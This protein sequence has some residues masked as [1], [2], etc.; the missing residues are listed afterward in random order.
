MSENTTPTRDELAA[1]LIAHGEFSRLGEMRNYENALACADAI[2]AL[3]AEALTAA[4]RE[5]DDWMRLAEQSPSSWL[6]RENAEALLQE[7]AK[8]LE[9]FA[10]MYGQPI[11][12]S[13]EGSCR[14]SIDS[15]DFREALLLLDRI[16]TASSK[17]KQG[18]SQL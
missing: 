14:V 17:M 2:H 6:A 9:P 11:R 10:D 3:Y 18:A 7:A 1:E 5:R 4:E 16:Q 8:V 12:L 13:A 15:K